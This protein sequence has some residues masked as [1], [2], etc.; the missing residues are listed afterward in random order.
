MM[1]DRALEAIVR[2]LKSYED[3]EFPS[4]ET[5]LET[6]AFCAESTNL[7]LDEVYRLRAALARERRKRKR[8]ETLYA[9]ALAELKLHL[10][11]IGSHP[12]D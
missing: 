6:G 10:G 3:E 12:L 2:R 9:S 1:S 11:R 7:L 5:T 8:A 4:S